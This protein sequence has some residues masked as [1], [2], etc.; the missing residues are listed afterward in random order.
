MT[1]PDGLGIVVYGFLV[2]TGGGLVLYYRERLDVAFWRMESRVFWFLPNSERY[3]RFRVRL[4]GA[5]FVLLGLFA[6]FLGLAT[7]WG[8]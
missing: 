7:L 1:L 2:V 4:V 6:L 5:F 3:V 8:R